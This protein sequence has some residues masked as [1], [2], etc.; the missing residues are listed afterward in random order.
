MAQ[1]EYNQQSYKSPEDISKILMD[2]GILY[3]HWGLRNPEEP[4]D[5]SVLAS[6]ANDISR[7]KKE[8]GYVEADMVALR[9]DTPGLS[10]ICNK[11]AR[12]HHHTDDEVRFVVEGK[13]VFEIQD[14]SEKQFLKITTTP[15]D[16][17]VIPANRRHLFYLT[18]EQTIRCIRLFKDES[19]WEAHF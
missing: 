8:K 7:L 5:A 1:L 2:H 15:G 3:E 6:Y 13:G 14:H 17:I 11:F 16:L 9:P 10:D 18:E 12:E 4:T 19:G